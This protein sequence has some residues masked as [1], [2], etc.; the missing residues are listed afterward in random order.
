MKMN[1]PVR[2]AILDM[3]N[4]VENMGITSIKRIADRFPLV[5]YDVF[6]VRYKAEVPGPGYDIY[7]SSGGPGDPL[8]GDGIWDKAYY[9]LQDQL[10]EHNLHAQHKKYA[11][12]ICHSFQMICHHMGIGNITHRPKESFGIVPVM[13]TEAGMRDPLLKDLHNPFYGADFRR[14]Q[15]VSPNLKRMKEM[16]IVITAMEMGEEDNPGGNALMAVRFSDAWFGTQFHPEAHPDGMLHY[17]R[18][19]EKKEMIL[20]QFGLNTYEEMMHNAI[21]PDRLTQTRDHVL[22][23]FIKNALDKILELSDRVPVLA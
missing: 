22:P 10:W 18:R 15:V 3:N 5:D 2:M 7:I 9:D 19:P 17:L 11:F 23:G 8:D 1:A 16:G 6:D 14:F 21:H 12:F 13:K 20:N 4:N